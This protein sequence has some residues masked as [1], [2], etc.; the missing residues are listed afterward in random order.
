MGG[1]NGHVV[2]EAFN[3]DHWKSLLHPNG[4]AH[5]EPRAKKRLF[6]FSSHDQA[7]FK[8]LGETLADHLDGLGPAASSPEFLAEFAHTLAVARSGLSWRASCVAETAADLRHQLTSGITEKP[9]RAPEGGPPRIGFIFTGQGAQWAGM[10]AELLDSHPVF[11]DSVARSA[12]LLASMGCDWDPATELRRPAAESRLKNPEISQPICTVL[13]IALVNELR[14]WG[15]TPSRV[16]GHSSGEIGAAYC[17]GALTH[18]D[19]I[20]V[21]YFRGKASSGLVGL[22]G[23]MMAVGCSFKE[24]RELLASLSSH[25]SGVATVACVNSPSSVTLSGDI[26]ALEQLRGFCEKQ[27]VF[28]RMLQV[29]VAYHSSHM[30]GA[31]ADYASSIADIEPKS[32][33]TDEVTMVSSV[34]GNETAPELFAQGV[35][36]NVQRVNGDDHCKLLT[37]LPPYPWNHSKVFRCDSRIAKE[38]LAQKFPTRSHLGAPVPMMDETQHVWRSFLRLE[39]EPW[40]RGHMVGSTVLLPGAGMTSI[41]LEACRQ[42]VAPGKTARAFRLQDVSLFAA[43]ALPEGVATE[44]IV[45]MRLHLSSTL[46]ST[47]AV[48]WEF[49]M[50]SCVGGDQLRDNCRGLMTIDYTEDTSTQMADEDAAIA[51]SRVQDYYRVHKECT[52]EYAKQDFYNHMN[53]AAWKYGEAFRGVQNCRAALP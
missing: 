33:E 25:L 22:K 35:P 45:H 32:S 16:A 20:A 24:A 39:D 1:T 17:A 23:G 47:P 52:L 34:T 26:G 15:V 9:T 2:L 27:K 30:Q 38:L 13:Q 4:V 28:A 36:V 31:A 5:E 43:M 18:R 51:A 7:G 41:V 29:D 10:G 14:S 53:K 6:T 21:A 37:N 3:P 8:R 50:S 40:L 44:V 49:T 11:R 12:A 48:W 46:G 19:A 42:L